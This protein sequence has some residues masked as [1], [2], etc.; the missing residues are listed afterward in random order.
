MH[1]G[2]KH[3]DNPKKS[4]KILNPISYIQKA[5]KSRIKNPKS[6][7]SKKVQ[8]SWNRN[9]RK[10]WKIPKIFQNLILR[11]LR[12]LGIL[13]KR[14]H[15]N[16]DRTIVVEGRWQGPLLSLSCDSY[17]VFC[18]LASLFSLVCPDREQV[19]FNDYQSMLF[20]PLF[21]HLSVQILFFRFQRFF[22]FIIGIVDHW[23]QKSLKVA[24]LHQNKQFLAHLL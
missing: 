23:T 7:R 13:Q 16:M 18:S 20:T 10:L 24:L 14:I 2:S 4:Y 22:G 5:L 8:N 6:K 19:L 17:S 11:I 1:S 3:R 12:I 15:K 21:M 9:I